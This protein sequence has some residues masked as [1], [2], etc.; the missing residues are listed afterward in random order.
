MVHSEPSALGKD[1]LQGQGSGGVAGVDHRAGIDM[2]GAVRLQRG[3]FRPV[4]EECVAAKE[5]AVLPDGRR[6]SEHVVRDVQ[7]VAAVAGEVAGDIVRVCPR[8]GNRS[9]TVALVG[10]R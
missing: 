10:K 9:Q 4:R 3:A 1:T 6:H 8:S 5:G 7:T 2:A